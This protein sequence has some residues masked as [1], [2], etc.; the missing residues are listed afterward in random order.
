MPSCSST[1]QEKLFC[2]RKCETKEKVVKEPPPLQPNC[3]WKFGEPSLTEEKTSPRKTVLSFPSRQV[4]GSPEKAS[5]I[6]RQHTQKALCQEKQFTGLCIEIEKIYIMT[7]QNCATS[8]GLYY[9]LVLISQLQSPLAKLPEVE[10]SQSCCFHRYVFFPRLFYPG[11]FQP[12]L[13][14]ISTTLCCFRWPTRLKWESL[15]PSCYVHSQHSTRFMSWK[16]EKMTNGGKEG[17]RGM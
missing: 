6:A 7:A 15:N 13:P 9:Y 12:Y 2:D 1:S 14:S 8:N 5:T 17:Q 11:L 4:F 3:A 16:P 10:P